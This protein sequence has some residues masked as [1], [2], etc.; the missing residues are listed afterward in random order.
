[1]DEGRSYYALLGIAPDATQADI[2][3]RYQKLVAALSEQIVAGKAP[4]PAAFNDIDTAFSALRD[5][6]KRAVYDRQLAESSSPPKMPSTVSPSPERQLRRLQFSFTGH[7][8]EYFRIWIVNLMLSILT[9]GIYSAWAKVRREQY[10]HRNLVLDGAGFD[11][12]ATPVSILKGRMVAVLLFCI[13]SVT[14]YIHPILHLVTILIGLLVVPWFIVRAFRFRAYNSSYRGLR[15]TFRGK[16]D[17]AFRAYIAYGLLMIITL[18]ICAPLWIRETRK[19]LINHLHYGHGQFHCELFA[20]DIF[21]FVLKAWLVVFVV[22]AAAG[23][24]ASAHPLLGILAGIVTLL[25]YIGVFPYLQMCLYN[26]VWSR[27]TLDNNAFSSEMNFKPY[28]AIVL[29]NWFFTLLTL[30]LYWPWAKV[31]MAR[32][33]AACTGITLLSGLDH[34]IAQATEH[35]S[36]FGDEAA[37]MFDLDIAI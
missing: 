16:Q 9:L 3:K 29:R 30:G 37:D 13:V 15:F 22:A 10:F 18:G 23:L 33:R 35:A 21:G 4:S 36:A 14:Q 20:K 5:P 7:G 11:Y 19:Y 2:E 17:G 31:N 26:Y 25:V 28:F 1:M 8:S 32:Y 34:F 27:T 24:L 12:H 6:D